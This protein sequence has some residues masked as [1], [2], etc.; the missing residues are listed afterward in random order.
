[1]DKIS[2][3]YQ[4]IG[5][6]VLFCTFATVYT[7]IIELT[8]TAASFRMNAG[9]FNIWFSM[10]ASVI[11]TYIGSICANDGK[12]SFRDIS[13]GSVSGAII[14]GTGAGYIENIGAC[15]AIGLVAGI[16]VSL[17]V[18]CFSQRVNQQ[19][20]MDSHGFLMPIVIVS[21]LGS[22][23]VLP[24]III[25]HYTIEGTYF[26]LGG[27]AETAW[28]SAGF[29]LTYVGVTIF[30]AMIA[31]LIGGCQLKCA[32]EEISDFSDSKLFA[33]DYGLYEEEEEKEFPASQ[34]GKNLYPD[35]D[36]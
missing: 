19:M 36:K 25:R 7:D 24:A 23:V 2:T 11:G 17:L 1:M 20:I 10:I 31:G 29:Q 33:T 32:K 28:E 5:S 6:G 35:L 26:A 4:L 34:S 12:P 22:F 9:A 30:I 27:Q 3:V 15:F 21:F 13:I 14:C 18:R 8:G 16:L